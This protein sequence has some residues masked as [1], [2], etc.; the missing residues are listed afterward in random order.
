MVHFLKTT[1]TIVSLGA[2]A[3]VGLVMHND[4]VTYVAVG[5]LAGYLGKV[6]GSS[7][8]ESGPKGP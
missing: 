1:M 4:P 8:E 3:V 7:S 5:A 6:N 2:I